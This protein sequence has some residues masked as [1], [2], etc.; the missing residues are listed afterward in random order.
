MIRG[1]GKYDIYKQTAKGHDYS[2][3]AGTASC[4]AGWAG[5]YLYVRII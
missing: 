2:F 3:A 1:E 5:R 4:A